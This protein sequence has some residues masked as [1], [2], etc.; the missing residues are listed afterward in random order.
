M[1]PVFR[2]CTQS[3]P[4]GYFVCNAKRTPKSLHF[5]QGRPADAFC[6]HAPYTAFL[7]EAGSQ[8]SPSATDASCS[9]IPRIPSIRNDS[10]DS[11]R[12]YCRYGS[13]QRNSNP[14]I[15]RSISENR[16][17]KQVPRPDCYPTISEAAVSSAHSATC[18]GARDLEKELFRSTKQAKFLGIRR[19][20]HSPDPLRSDRGKSTSGLQPQKTRTAF[21]SPVA[22]LRG[23]T[24]RVLAW[25]LAPWK[26]RCI[27]WGRPFPDDLLG[28]D[29]QDYCKIPNPIS[30][31]FWILWQ[32]RN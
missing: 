10:G 7:P 18:P 26:C 16:W 25:K 30:A 6:W 27:Y 13:C 17:S 2:A 14:A 1:V 29:S 22:L 31:G 19:R 28:Q 9:K 24:P 32:A 8:A 21:V 5:F 12:N 3:T 4:L 20:F 23:R 15:Q 11:V